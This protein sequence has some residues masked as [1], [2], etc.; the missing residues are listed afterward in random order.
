MAGKTPEEILEEVYAQRASSRLR[1]TREELLQAFHGNLTEKL[2][3]AIESNR[4]LMAT[5]EQEIK[6]N[7]EFLISEIEQSDKRALQLL[8]TIPGVDEFS[9]TI[10]LTEIGGRE[11][12]IRAFKDDS[13][14]SAWLG[15]CPGNN[16]SN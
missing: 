8:Q 16:I 5:L 1:A 4:R 14:F 13:K 15:L 12:F 9:A 10:V 3:R 7:K 2:K 6:Q 11:N